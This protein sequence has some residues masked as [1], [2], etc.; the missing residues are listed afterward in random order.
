[1]VTADEKYLIT[2]NAGSDSV[3][4]F[5][6]KDDYSLELISTIPSGG[7]GPNS[8]AVHDGL[9]FAPTLTVMASPSVMRAH[10]VLSP[11]MRAT[12]WA[13]ACQKVVS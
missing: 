5:A 3:T 8:V 1:M 4:S 12:L 7:V 6:I 11:T 10:H 9:V 13:S 2:V